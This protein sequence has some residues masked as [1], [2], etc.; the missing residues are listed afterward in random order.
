M[1][2][3]K[4]SFPPFI[5]YFSHH[6]FF[7]FYLALVVHSPTIGLFNEEFSY[8]IFS[9]FVAFTYGKI[10]HIKLSEMNVN[11]FSEFSEFNVQILYSKFN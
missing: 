11:A 3:C 10:I 9:K 8:K 2:A 4:D 1:T 7:N 6:N 5:P